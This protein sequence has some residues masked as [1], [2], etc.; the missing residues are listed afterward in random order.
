[1]EYKVCPKCSYA[2]DTIET[3]CQKCALELD[4]V[5]PASS[6]DV[7]G[8]VKHRHKKEEPPSMP[9]QQ[10]SPSPNFPA[11]KNFVDVLQ[12]GLSST[13]K[14][15]A[16]RYPFANQYISKVIKWAQVVFFVSVLFSALIALGVVIGGAGPAFNDKNPLV[17][18]G[19]LLMGAIIFGVGW[20]IALYNRMIQL[21]FANMLQCFI[22]IEENTRPKEVE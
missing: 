13:S 11:R 9:E 18:L 16:N 14:D 20:L 1:M 21:A 12:L 8:S 19:G 17:F 6:S 15:P 4:W 7:G 22:Q 2:N 3:H 10:S 5:E